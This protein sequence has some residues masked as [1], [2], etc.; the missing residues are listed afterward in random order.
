[1]FTV[2]AGA[3]IEALNILHSNLA[4]FPFFRAPFSDDAKSKIFWGAC[5]NIFTEDIP[6]VVVQ[7]CNLYDN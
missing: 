7:V 3:D 1:V 6:Q 2:L 4:G 5:L